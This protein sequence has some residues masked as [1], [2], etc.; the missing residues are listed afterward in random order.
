MP[1]SAGDALAISAYWS[2]GESPR[3]ALRAVP[4]DLQQSGLKAKFAQD[5]QRPSLQCDARTGRCQLGDGL[6][7]L[8]FNIRG[9]FLQRES[10]N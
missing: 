1:K 3:T 8:V 9:V 10:E 5:N 6:V 4:C 2:R 7:D